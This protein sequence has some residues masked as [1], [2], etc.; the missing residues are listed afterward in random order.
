MRIKFLPHKT[1]SLDYT[2]CKVVREIYSR[3][4]LKNKNNNQKNPEKKDEII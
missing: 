2:E 3:L 1:K 4:V